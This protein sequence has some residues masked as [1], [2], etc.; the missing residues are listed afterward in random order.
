MSIVTSTLHFVHKLCTNY[1][2]SKYYSTFITYD[3]YQQV[4]KILT[5]SMKKE[6]RNN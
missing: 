1:Y 2:L 6:N 3:L 4:N 5:S